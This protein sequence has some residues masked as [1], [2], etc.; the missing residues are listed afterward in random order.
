MAQCNHRVK[1]KQCKAHA[2]KGK[3]K[4]LFH[5]KGKKYRRK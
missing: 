1:N 5:T 2:L 3:H 4:C